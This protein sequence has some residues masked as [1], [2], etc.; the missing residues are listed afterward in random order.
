M[1]KHDKLSATLHEYAQIA[2]E[3]S[4]NFSSIIIYDSFMFIPDYSCYAVGKNKGAS[5]KSCLMLSRVVSN[6]IQS[7]VFSNN[8]EQLR[9]T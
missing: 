6:K 1:M 3:F 7:L 2:H 4:I 9:T 8:F 5:P